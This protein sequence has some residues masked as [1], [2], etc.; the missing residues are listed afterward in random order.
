MENQPRLGLGRFMPNTITAKAPVAAAA[1][2]ARRARATPAEVLHRKEAALEFIMTGFKQSLNVRHY[3]FQIIAGD[4][5]RRDV[6]VDADLD[7]MRRH[8]ISIQ[9]M[10][11]LCKHL[12]E[13]ME[14]TRI[15]AAEA[16]GESK[17]LNAET[18]V[19]RIE[20]TEQS[21]VVLAQVRATAKREQELRRKRPVVPARNNTNATHGPNAKEVPGAV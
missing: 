12:L 18:A 7:L 14:D 5:T 21:M 16:K 3:S 13:T 20:F 10:P 6:L 9:E 11:L 17:N 1:D 8:G 2:G 4:R 19:E 15:A